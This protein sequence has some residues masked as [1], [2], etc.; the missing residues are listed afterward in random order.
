MVLNFRPMHPRQC[1]IPV[2]W[3]LPSFWQIQ[4]LIR[5]PAFYSHS[6]SR[7]ILMIFL[8]WVR[9]HFE[10][11]QPLGPR[12]QPPDRNVTPCHGLTQTVSLTT[13]VSSISCERRV[14]QTYRLSG[15]K[16]QRRTSGRSSSCHCIS[17]QCHRRRWST[18]VA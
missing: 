3:H 6:V 11:Q 9:E 1:E 16:L 12:L 10:G 17:R 13:A 5:C 18:P 7:P 8:M 2:M 14:D 4:H 15:R